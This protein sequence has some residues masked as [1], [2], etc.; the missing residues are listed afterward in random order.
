[1]GGELG[2]MSAV[3]EDGRFHLRQ[4]GHLVSKAL[5]ANNKGNICMACLFASNFWRIVGRPA[6]AIEC[7]KKAL[8]LAPKI[9]KFSALLSMANV[10]HRTHHSEDAVTVLYKAIEITP[11]NPALHFTLGNIQATL[12]NFNKSAESFSMALKLQPHF[13]A[14][15]RRRHAVVCHQ[16]IE[17]ALEEQQHAL[18]ETLKEL[19]HYKKQHDK[20]SQILNKIINEQAS[21]ETRMQTINGYEHSKMRL[22]MAESETRRRSK[23][24]QS[25]RSNDKWKPK[26]HPGNC[27]QTIDEDGNI[28]LTC[29]VLPSD[30]SEVE[31]QLSTFDAPPNLED[32]TNE[33]PRHF[34]NKRNDNY[35]DTNDVD[36][37][38]RKFES[39]MKGINDE[40]ET[41]SSNSNL[42]F[43][44]DTFP[45]TNSGMKSKSGGEKSL[46]DDFDIRPTLPAMYSKYPDKMDSQYNKDS[47]KV[48]WF[49]LKQI[50]GQDWPTKEICNL[51]N[52]KREWNEYPSVFLSPENKG[53]E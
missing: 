48:S 4:Y 25:R 39:R 22:Q 26:K 11:D 47:K 52:L 5:K 2:L 36:L 12:L 32:I 7:Q 38:L 37:L 50:F 13:E 17:Q 46:N 40:S 51:H 33:F 9:W 27:A 10:L 18:Q 45:S 15:K 20:W 42:D 53:F 1:M 29:T 41:I 8:H 21:L 3:L 43:E 6:E 35:L 28:Y 44:K 31:Q 14:A 49:H 19:R 16:R 24:Y 23:L 34:D 30:G